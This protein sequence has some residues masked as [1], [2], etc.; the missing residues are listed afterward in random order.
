MKIYL[1]LLF[2][3]CI[4]FSSCEQDK[5][6]T[7]TE[8]GS[9][10]GVI[11][12]NATGAEEA[13]P[14]FKKGMLLLHSFQYEDA[15]ESFREAKEIDPDFV[16]AYWGEALTYHKC[17]WNLQDYDAGKQIL[18]S[19]GKTETERSAKAATEFE[20]D[21]LKGAE[22]LYGDG[23]KIERDDLYALHMEK[24]HKKYPENEEVAS[25]YALSLLCSVEV[26]RD[27]EVYGRSAKVAQSIIQENPNHPGALHYLIHAYDDPEHAHKALAA[28]DAY[29]KVA[30][31]AAHALHMPSHIYV[32]LGMWDDVVRSNDRAYNASVDRMERKGLDTDARDYHSFA[33]WQYGLLQQ[34]LT[35]RASDMLDSMVVYVSEKPTYRA[36]SYLINMKG[37]WL[38]ETGLWSH[39]YKDI[40]VD[41][42]D[43]N[44]QMVAFYLY[45]D[46]M[47]NGFTEEDPEHIQSLIRRLEKKIEEASL[48]ISDKGVA[49]C[50]SGGANQYLPNS[51]NIKGA[52]VHLYQMK[53]LLERLNGELNSEGKYLKD[54]FQLSNEMSYSFGPPE[55]VIPAAE[56]YADW[57]HRAG[58]YDDALQMWDE[59]LKKG[60]LRIMALKGK[61]ETAKALNDKNLVVQLTNEI[62]DI[63]KAEDL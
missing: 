53:A 37:R 8:D 17:L 27:E 14:L 16:L 15:R 42:E 24:L 9:V 23:D 40:E 4:L 1:L 54:A 41:L 6:S 11:T 13:Q 34:G 44:I 28:A 45:T 46:A 3:L 47:S 32:A 25:L 19:L 31:D 33:W 49:M 7:Q 61:R 21:L 29:A 58:R 56:S 63:Q 38:A 5:K 60:P 59:A 39:R 43:M 18:E 35:N 51:E 62:R 48:M 10:L 50:S 20:K 55:I 22:I 30:P 2:S 52:K 12:W 57:L 26:G 36:K